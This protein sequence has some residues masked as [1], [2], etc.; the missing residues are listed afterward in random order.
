MT[1][2]DPPGRPQE[3]PSTVRALTATA[4]QEAAG[5]A[6]KT[7]AKVATK[8]G[9]AAKNAAAKVARKQATRQAAGK[10]ATTLATA[11]PM[12]KAAVVA[13][14]LA[15]RTASE[16]VRRRGGATTGREAGERLSRAGT[17]K[18][19]ARGQSDSSGSS[20][21]RWL[22]LIVA[23]VL[24]GLALP[25]AMVFAVLAAGGGGGPPVGFV[26]AY[27]TTNQTDGGTA[28]IPPIVF[29]A[30]ASAAAEA[31]TIAPGCNLRPAI[32]A[33][34]GYVESGH[35]T[36]GGAVADGNGDV[37]PPII[38][39][40]LDGSNGTAAISDSD[41]GRWDGDTA[42]DRAVGPMQ[43]IPSSWRTHGRDGNRDGVGDPHNVFDAALGAVS[44]LCASS[45]VDLDASEQAL[46]DALFGYNR[47]IVYV[48]QVVE[49]IQFYDTALAGGTAGVAGTDIRDVGNGI[50]VHVS[51]A[52]DVTRLLADAAADGVVLAGGGYRDPAAQI[53]ARK[54]NCGT[55][56]YAIYEMPAG[57]CSPPTARPGTSRHEQGLA[58]DF[59]YQGRII[60]SRSGVAWNWLQANAASYGLYN[61][62]SEPWHWSTDGK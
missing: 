32:L 11:H 4:R 44:H 8:A 37:R 27:A 18:R 25:L 12:L 20:G 17:A 19:W 5:A 62:P 55:S 3:R 31:G 38:G 45:P 52:D 48:D 61:L 41:G 51:I 50:S 2:D 58:I 22:V 15:G 6:R 28:D 47:S 54:A 36:H 30:Y 29:Q 53:A 39:I 57:Q 1:A 40:P 14:G 34:I 7:G 24:L 26:A 46:R 23:T 9:S 10:V 49:R 43:F 59:T 16:G 21:R 35:G 56:N 42:W 13:A 60:S 33:G